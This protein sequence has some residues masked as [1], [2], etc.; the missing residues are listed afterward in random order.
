MLST[1]ILFS[2]QNEFNFNQYQ[3]NLPSSITISMWHDKIA[4]SLNAKSQSHNS[5]TDKRKFCIESTIAGNDFDYQKT[6]MTMSRF[7]AN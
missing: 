4:S 3:I 7:A 1:K 5:L 2:F 6:A